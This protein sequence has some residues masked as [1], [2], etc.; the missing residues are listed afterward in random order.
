[1]ARSDCVSELPPHRVATEL[2]RI[3]R[4]GN[5]NR[6][7]NHLGWFIA[8]DEEVEEV[9]RKA[10]AA[11]SDGCGPGAAHRVRIAVG[12]FILNYPDCT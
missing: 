6:V 2:E 1:M 3:V 4:K 11:E 7:A 8:R 9:I 10:L 12:E 5:P